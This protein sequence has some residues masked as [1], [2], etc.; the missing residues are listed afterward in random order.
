M[1]EE[2][3]QYHHHPI[4]AIDRHG[5]AK[6]A[7]PNLRIPNNLAKGGHAILYRSDFCDPPSVQLVRGECEAAVKKGYTEM[8]ELGS[9]HCPISSWNVLLLS[10][11]I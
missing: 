3:G 6:N 4:P 9:L 7:F 8:K 11:S 10:T 2:I 1:Q 5:M